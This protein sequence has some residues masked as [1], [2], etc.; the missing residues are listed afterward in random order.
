MR[1]RKRHRNPNRGAAHPIIA[2][3]YPPN[4]IW[5]PTATTMDADLGGWQ[6]AQADYFADGG[7]FDRI[8][9]PGK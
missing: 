6:K 8:Y 4:A 5:N 3:G 9:T 1:F 2:V 7:L